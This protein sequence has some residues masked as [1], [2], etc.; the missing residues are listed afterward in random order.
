M[1]IIAAGPTVADGQNCLGTEIQIT[2][3]MASCGV[4]P[5]ISYHL[6][7]E[8]L[9]LDVAPSEDC[10]HFILCVCSDDN[11]TFL[12]LLL[13]VTKSEVELRK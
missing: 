9:L 4:H 2:Q 12:P 11:F 1:S 8:N 5:S 6:E 10:C 7:G 13:P 3:T